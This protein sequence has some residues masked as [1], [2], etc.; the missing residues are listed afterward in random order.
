MT[1]WTARVRFMASQK[2]RGVHEEVFAVRVGAIEALDG[3]LHGGGQFAVG[4]AELL[5]QH[6]SDAGVGLGD[7][8]GKHQL[9]D[10]VIHGSRQNWTDRLPFSRT[11]WI[12]NSGIQ[13]LRTRMQLADQSVAFPGG[14]EPLL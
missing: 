7:A 13:A 8:D 6:V 10:V 11:K 2:W 12:E 4:A 1:S 3:L 5:Q 9:F 14:H